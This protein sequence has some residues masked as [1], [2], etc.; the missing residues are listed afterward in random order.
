[1][2][3][4]IL[5]ILFSFFLFYIGAQAQNSTS[6]SYSGT[7]YCNVGFATVLRSGD[8]AGG[9]YSANPIGLVIDSIT[10]T[11]DLGKSIPQ[12][13]TV[14][15]TLNCPT[16]Q[17]IYT[18]DITIHSSL[19]SIKYSS[20]TFCQAVLLPVQSIILKGNGT[21]L[22]GIYTS[23]PLGLSYNSITGDITPSLSAYGSYQVVYT[24][25]DPICGT[26][27]DTTNVSIVDKLTPQIRIIAT[28]DTICQ[29]TSVTFTATPVNGGTAPIYQW[30]KN[31]LPIKD[32]SN[33]TLTYKPLDN[34]TIICKMVSNNE[35]ILTKTVTSDILIVT[36]NKPTTGLSNVFT[37]C[38]VYLWHGN[39]YTTTGTYTFDSL[40][41]NGCDSLT[42]LNLTITQPPTRD[43]MVTTCNGFTWNGTN[44]TSTGNITLN[45]KN[46]VGCDSVITLHLTINQPTTGDT[47][48]IAC[49]SFTWYGNTYTSSGNHIHTFINAAGCDSVVTLNLTINQPTSGD[50]TVITCGSLKW[51][52]TNYTS[53]GTATHILPNVNGCDSVV[54]LHLTINQPTIGD[55]TVI[56][57][58]N[59]SWYGTNFISSGIAKHTFMNTAGCDSIVT[60]HLTINQPTTG[61]TTA[62]V[63]NSFNWHGTNYNTTGTYTYNSLNSKGCDSLITL[64]L[65]IK[66]IPIVTPII[67]LNTLY[68]GQKIDLT[69]N[70]ISGIWSSQ[71]S[72]IA[73]VN[74][75]GQ[76]L[77]I[78]K[79]IDTIYYVVSSSC[80][81]DTAN[82]RIDVLPN[83]LFIPNVFSPNG[84]GI[85][86]IFLVRGA[87]ILIKQMELRIFDS[88]GNELFLS[89][90]DINDRSKG[91]DGT[92]K[93]QPQPPGV[94]VYVARIEMIT[95]EIQIKKGAINLIR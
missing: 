78:S 80:G 1:M 19:T 90:G 70:T 29:G 17:C 40:N 82:F 30:I 43:T 74:E 49:S 62:I 10:G 12:T 60:L 65:T 5:L 71:Y 72:F 83:T 39:T 32:S 52:G 68:V 58:G 89:K 55:T 33:V 61:D 59:F 15:Y 21:I 13:Y 88:W 44:Y 54:T 75:A 27:H 53:T 91:W 63:C 81:S 18:T 8:S 16:T 31:G 37:C 36:I 77:G 35:C 94:Y 20:D 4:I 56:A 14:Q 69:E 95:G 3:R 67:G 57:C 11:I 76:V 47:I 79:G 48:V 64:Q 24:Y 34:D 28:A 46:A 50:T 6:I 26:I 87:G 86:D 25:T 7:P 73:T 66:L 23:T 92:F 85:N 38:G 51:Y 41:V 93:G 84:S 9:N 42:T 2:R 22:D 45:I